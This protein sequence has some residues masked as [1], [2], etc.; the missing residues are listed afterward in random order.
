MAINFYGPPSDAPSD[1]YGRWVARQVPRREVTSYPKSYAGDSIPG[2]TSKDHAARDAFAYGLRKIRDK[3]T[4]SVDSMLERF[5]FAIQSATAAASQNPENFANSDEYLA[6]KIAKEESKLL[7]LNAAVIDGLRRQHKADLDILKDQREEIDRLQA[8]FCSYPLYDGDAG[9]RRQHET[10][11]EIMKDQKEQIDRLRLTWPG[12]SPP[13]HSRVR[14]K[15]DNPG[16]QSWFEKTLVEVEKPKSPFTVYAASSDSLMVS[17]PKP[18]KERI[19]MSKTRIAASLLA[20]AVLGPLAFKTMASGWGDAYAAVIPDEVSSEMRL[21]EL[22]EDR[23]DL[24]ERYAELQ[25]QLEA[26][27]EREALKQDIIAAFLRGEEEVEKAL[28]LASTK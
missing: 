4:E 6:S 19:P 21:A 1:A 5:D 3:S 16:L 18:E 24:A 22:F 17:E 12:V 11:L 15:Y 26:D 28:A 14:R 20:A 25:L 13:T 8:R 23:E 7:K 9:L 27:S 2:F 10:D